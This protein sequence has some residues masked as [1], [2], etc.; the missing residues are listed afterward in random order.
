MWPL[1]YLF[2]LRRKTGLYI[3]YI[4]FIWN[5]ESGKSIIFFRNKV[6]RKNSGFGLSR[7]DLFMKKKL[8]L[9]AMAVSLSAVCL[10]GCTQT[11]ASESVT[12]ETEVE[13]T[14]TTTEASIEETDAEANTNTTETTVE[15]SENSTAEPAV[16]IDISNTDSIC[17][18]AKEFGMYEADSYAEYIAVTKPDEVD[19]SSVYYD[20]K[21]SE[22]ANKWYWASYLINESPSPENLVTE[23]VICMDYKEVVDDTEPNYLTEIHMITFIDEESANELYELT[24]QMISDYDHFSSGEENGYS[25]SISYVGTETRRLAIGVYKQGNAVIYINNNCCEFFC[26]E[27]GLVS[28]MTLNK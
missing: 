13:T 6:I 24:R 19:Y 8:L 26:N 16:D 22:E 10:A 5:G 27:L 12:S 23:C 25:Y 14:T 28:P 3:L 2:T 20:I 11:P 4:R 9:K 17:K 15:E 18:T 1:F 21:D 7:E